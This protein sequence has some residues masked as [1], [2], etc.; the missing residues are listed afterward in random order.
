M[1]EIT[2]DSVQSIRERETRLHSA[3]MDGR[4]LAYFLY[5]IDS[6]C[7]ILAKVNKPVSDELRLDILTQA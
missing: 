6:C 4:S 7:A 2:E 3:T 5:E 1:Y